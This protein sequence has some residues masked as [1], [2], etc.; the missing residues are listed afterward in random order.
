M[1]IAYIIV[2]KCDLIF[3]SFSDKAICAA[4]TQNESVDREE[5]LSATS[6]SVHKRVPN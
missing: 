6:G 4:V 1:L 5:D 3:Q 2:I